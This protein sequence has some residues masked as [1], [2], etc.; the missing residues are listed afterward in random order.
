MVF[1]LRVLRRTSM[2][3]PISRP[4]LAM[5][6]N[7]SPWISGGCD[8]L[9]GRAPGRF[10]LL[11][12]GFSRAMARSYPLP[13]E[14][15][16]DAR[17]GRKIFFN[18]CIC[19]LIWRIRPTFPCSFTGTMR[20]YTVHPVFIHREIKISH[21]ITSLLPAEMKRAHLEAQKSRE[22]LFALVA[23]LA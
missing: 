8:A 10:F 7:R 12:Q 18:P 2:I 11:I 21:S 23:V 20:L 3:K 22:N 6:G 14:K 19:G 4:S 9:V 1:F 5:R 13:V 17:E 15:S 16:R